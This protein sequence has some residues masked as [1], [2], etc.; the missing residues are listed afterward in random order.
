MQRISKKILDFWININKNPE[1]VTKLPNN[2]PIEV[3]EDLSKRINIPEK[4]QLTI[5]LAK[6]KKK[7]K[8]IARFR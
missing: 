2:V 4:L 3:L 1:K 6:L 5:E 8:K 7:N